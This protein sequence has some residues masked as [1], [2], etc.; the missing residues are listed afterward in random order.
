MHDELKMIEIPSLAFPIQ[1]SISMKKFTTANHHY[2]RSRLA[3]PHISNEQLPSLTH[4]DER[5]SKASSKFLNNIRLLKPEKNVASVIANNITLP[6]PPSST[7]SSF[8]NDVHLYGSGEEGE[9]GE[10]SHHAS[11]FGT[12]TLESNE[13]SPEQPLNSQ[14]SQTDEVKLVLE[15]VLTQTVELVEAETRAWNE[16][17][18]NLDGVSYTPNGVRLVNGVSD[19]S[20]YREPSEND[21]LVFTNQLSHIKMVMTKFILRYKTAIPFLKPVDSVALKIPHYYRIIRDPMDLNTIKNRLHFFW[22]RSAKECLSDFDLIFKNCFYFNSPTDY[23]YIAGRK[24]QEH[25]QEKFK[26][27]PVPETQIPCPEQPS[28]DEGMLSFSFSV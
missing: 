22:Y 27:L 25:I 28:L 9:N 13:I 18:L 16:F 4:E 14:I 17:E 3:P 21:P 19:L 8:D 12:F 7:R 11:D 26:Q 15:D 10:D 5:D 24:L 6:S 1:H 2:T 23:V 20:F